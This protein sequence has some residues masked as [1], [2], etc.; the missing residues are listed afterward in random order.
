MLMSSSL[1]ARSAVEPFA[2]SGSQTGDREQVEQ[3]APDLGQTAATYA[4]KAEP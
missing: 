4:G 1:G 3:A 2:Q